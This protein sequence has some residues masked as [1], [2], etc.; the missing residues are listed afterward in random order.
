MTNTATMMI[1]NAISETFAAASK[2]DIL[3]NI[4]ISPWA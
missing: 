3:C 2:T 4:V 1:G